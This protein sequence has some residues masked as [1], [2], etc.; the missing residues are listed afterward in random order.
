ME[1][2]TGARASEGDTKRRKEEEEGTDD[3]VGTW[4]TQQ[5]ED[6]GQELELGH[7]RGRVECWVAQKASKNQGGCIEGDRV[8][9]N[10]GQGRDGREGEKH[11]D[12]CAR[13][14]EQQRRMNCM[15]QDRIEGWAR[16]KAGRRERQ[17]GRIW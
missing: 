13:Q 4:R 12:W 2:R 11:S 8:K 15:A 1:D 17:G 5:R 3:R 16:G 14:L 6:G 9:H 10:V 7:G